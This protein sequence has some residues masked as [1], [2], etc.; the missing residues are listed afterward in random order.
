MSD[1]E[2]V[3]MVQYQ[4]VASRRQS[5]DSLL[6]QVPVLS[7]TAQAFLFTIALGSTSR[8]ARLLAA[9]L[10]LAASLASIQLM[11]KHRG[12][13]QSDSERLE[14]FEKQQAARG[15]C[16]I[17][18]R[19]PLREGRVLGR[20]IRKLSSYKVWLF[21]LV[22]FAAVALWLVLGTFLALPAWDLPSAIPVSNTKYGT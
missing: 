19:P 4:V 16:V 6:W 2:S 8:F 13:E 20:W 14:A 7:L 18:G 12:H 21:I 11:V 15:F 17:H 1:K 22:L 10:A 3:E 9:G 5:R